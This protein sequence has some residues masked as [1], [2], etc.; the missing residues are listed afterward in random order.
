MWVVAQLGSRDHYLYPRAMEALGRLAVCVTDIYLPHRPPLKR[1]LARFGPF[2]R[3]TS[4]T[5]SGIPPERITSNS[6]RGLL[7][8]GG[9]QV[10]GHFSRKL[11][12]AAHRNSAGLVAQKAAATIRSL[13]V[14]GKVNYLGYCGESLEAIR[15]AKK[16]GG[17]A[18]VVQYDGAW[19]ADELY[20][21]ERRA[22]PE[23]TG[24]VVPRAQDWRDRVTL[25]WRLADKVIVN[26]AWVRDFVIQEGVAREKVIELSLAYE[27]S[28]QSARR[29]A[30]AEPMK[31]L[32]VGSVSLQKGFH[33]AALAFAELMKREI[34]CN[35]RVIG[36]LDIPPMQRARFANCITFDG[37]QP[38][39]EVRKAYLD[40]DVFLFP[41]IAD[42]F[43]MTQI[44]AL[45]AGVPVI[46]SDKCGDV[47]ENEISGWR[48]GA[49]T[50]TTLSATLMSIAANRQRICEMRGSCRARA[51]TFSRSTFEPKLL[52]I[53]A[54]LDEK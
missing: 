41:T 23:W 29:E 21:R 7:G 50:P 3:M 16:T 32:W 22:Y 15:A 31:L 37:P 39:D 28:D 53:V 42:G 51:K 47:V 44:E 9:F 26:S 35:F 4:R 11:A 38:K 20:E 8:L 2:R 45:A 6:L 46:A 54:A 19:G 30:V 34:S 13:S 5:I 36:S 24:S 14:G 49:I 1:V 40:A 33:L 12:V 10:A 17:N 27:C 18:I 52:E 48:L 43:G 25:E